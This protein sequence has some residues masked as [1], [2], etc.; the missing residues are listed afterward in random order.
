[1]CCK[2]KIGI[3]RKKK[4]EVYLVWR[5]CVLIQVPKPITNYKY[6]K[7]NPKLIGAVCALNDLGF[8]IAKK[9]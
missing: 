1:M 8:F 5:I 6:L 2:I 7:L 4:I 3:I 9:I